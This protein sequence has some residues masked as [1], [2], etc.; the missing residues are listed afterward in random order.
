M[1]EWGDI[2]HDASIEREGLD[3]ENRA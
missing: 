3:M 1:A 2:H